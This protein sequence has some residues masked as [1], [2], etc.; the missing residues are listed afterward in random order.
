M[1]T[2]IDI[3]D[4]LAVRARKLAV[5]Q[6]TTLRALVEAGLRKILLEHQ[7]ESASPVIQLKGFGHRIWKDINPDRYVREQRE[8]WS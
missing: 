7:T 4:D 6:R 8:K 5:D 3:A 1:R 2:T